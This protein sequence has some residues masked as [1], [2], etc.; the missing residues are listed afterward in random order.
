MVKSCFYFILS[1][2]SHGKHTFISYT[3]DNRKP[4]EIFPDWEN[5]SL[6]ITQTSTLLDFSI[7]V[8]S[9]DIGLPFSSM[10]MVL[11]TPKI[12]PITYRESILRISR[13]YMNTL[14]DQS[15]YQSATSMLVQSQLAVWWS[16]SMHGLLK[17]ACN[18]Q[19]I[20]F[21]LPPVRHLSTC[22]NRR[23]QK[24][25]FLQAWAYPGGRQM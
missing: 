11:K 24:H 25:Y 5:S 22:G 15:V 18:K 13:G 20:Y 3:T 8:T 16:G 19:T 10:T 2:P 1:L 23:P 21:K 14:P 9:W 7:Y 4:E 6:V 17:K 12:R